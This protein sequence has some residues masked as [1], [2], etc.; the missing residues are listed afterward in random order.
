MENDWETRRMKQET[1]FENQSVSCPE[2]LNGN[3][4]IHHQALMVLNPPVNK[5]YWT[6]SSGP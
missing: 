5:D 4:K 1:A 2:R 6:T 3:Y